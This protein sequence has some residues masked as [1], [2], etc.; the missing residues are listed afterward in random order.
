MGGFCFFFSVLGVWVWGVV[1]FFFF[2]FVFFFFFLGFWVLCWGGVFV[3]FFWGF[4]VLVV[5]FG[6]GWGCVLSAR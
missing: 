2:L 1:F 3:F 5:G 4:G 6:G